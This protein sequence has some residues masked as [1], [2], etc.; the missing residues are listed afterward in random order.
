V[1]PR[2]AAG[3]SGRWPSRAV[4]NPPQAAAVRTSW[5]RATTATHRPRRA[6]G[7]R[8]R[9]SA[10]T[11]ASTARPGEQVAGV[12]V[13]AVAVVGGDHRVHPGEPGQRQRPRGHGGRVQ[14]DPG[15]AEQAVGGDEGQAAQGEHADHPRHG[16]HHRQ[17]RQPR[18]VEAGPG[19]EAV[20]EPQHI[21]RRDQQVEH[22]VLRLEGEQLLVVGGAGERAVQRPV[23]QA[24]P[25]RRATGENRDQDPGGGDR[26]QPGRHQP[27]P[28]RAEPLPQP[29]REGRDRV[30]QRRVVGHVDPPRPPVVRRQR[31]ATALPCGPGAEAALVAVLGVAS[32]ELVE[33]EQ[34]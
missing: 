30:E 28:G 32:A 6:P 1:P 33:G 9:P 11:T 25:D 8:S 22:V 27:H 12:S 16:H 19:P 26:E 5:A 7:S 17:G 13:A 10:A 34:Q 23:A 15:G 2:S 29:D 24:E 18:Q 4:R 14:A 3:P 21:G 20:V 31:G